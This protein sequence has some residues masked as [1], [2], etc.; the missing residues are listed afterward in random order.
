[1]L[2]QISQGIVE[3]K[4]DDVLDSV[5]K[6]LKTGVDPLAILDECRQGMQIVGDKFEKGDFFLAEMILSAEVFKSAV[7]ELKPHLIHSTPKKKLAKDR[8][9]AGGHTRSWQEHIWR[10]SY[11]RR[12]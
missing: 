12:V 5:K 10:S 3:L 4:K 9:A 6:M 1:M 8:N 2:N 11:G 7:A